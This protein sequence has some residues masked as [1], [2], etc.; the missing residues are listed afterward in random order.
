MNMS[1]LGGIL[2]SS[3]EQDAE[4]TLSDYNTKEC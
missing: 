2:S 3:R 1:N 4:L